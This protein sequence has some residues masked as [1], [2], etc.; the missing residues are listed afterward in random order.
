MATNRSVIKDGVRTS[1]SCSTLIQLIRSSCVGLHDAAALSQDLKKRTSRLAGG[2]STTAQIP[3]FNE[4]Q[5]QLRALMMLS[6]KV[7]VRWEGEVIVAQQAGLKERRDT[8]R[9]P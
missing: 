3:A 2:R 7:L 6:G 8:H 1:T 5:A 4:F 9:N